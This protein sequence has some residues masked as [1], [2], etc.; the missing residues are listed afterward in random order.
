MT[1]LGLLLLGAGAFAAFYERREPF[2]G[3][4][5]TTVKPWVIIALLGFGLLLLVEGS[6]RGSQSKNSTSY[7][8]IHTSR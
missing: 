1:L 4:T 8:V 5:R 7:P 3:E 6:D 2:Q